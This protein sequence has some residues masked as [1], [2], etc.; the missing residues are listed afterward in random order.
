MLGDAPGSR[1]AGQEHVGR[2]ARVDGD[3]V[4]LGDEARELSATAGDRLEPRLPPPHPNGVSRR[5]PNVLALDGERILLGRR[6]R[7]LERPR[8]YG[9]PDLPRLQ[10]ERPAVSPVVTDPHEPRRQREPDRA[11][12]AGDGVAV[13]AIRYRFR[14]GPRDGAKELLDPVGEAVGVAV[15]IRV[16]ERE[17]LAVGEVGERARKL[18]G[19]ERLRVPHPHRQDRD[20]ATERRLEL[21]PHPVV[22]VVEPARAVRAR[23]GQPAIADQRDDYARAGERV[24]HSRPV[25]DAALDRLAGHEHLRGS[26]A[27][28]QAPEQEMRLEIRVLGSIVDEDRVL[29]HRAADHRRRRAACALRPGRRPASPTGSRRPSPTSRRPA[30]AGG[31]SRVWLTR[32]R[33]ENGGRRGHLRSPRRRRMPPLGD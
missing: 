7:G 32:I 1:R 2:S 9:D 31:A 8:L 13:P 6:D 17:R 5:E 11:A 23:G 33:Y 25:V 15:E 10:P 30:Y 3:V 14:L 21:D 4:L 29:G 26:E 24:H 20:L 16:R 18:V 27:S 28:R 19:G 12:D 22:G